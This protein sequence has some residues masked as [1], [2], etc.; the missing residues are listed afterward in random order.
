MATATGAIYSLPTEKEGQ[1]AMSSS[2][3]SSL[4][5]VAMPAIIRGKEI[6]VPIKVDL[7][8]KGARLVDTFC[9]NLYH[10][11]ML[12]EEF[13]AR[14]CTDL[15]LPIGFHSRVTLQ[16]VEQIQA[17]QILVESIRMYAP[18]SIPNWK[19][20]VC[21]IQPITIG[22][23][24]GSIDFSDKVDW[25]PM[26]DC[27][28]PEDFAATTT[29]DLGLP[30][31]IEPA[32]AHKI[33]EALFRW[34]Y[35]IVQNPMLSPA[36]TNLLPEFK[37]NETKVNFVSPNQVVDMVTSLWKRAK[38]SSL[39]EVAAAPQPQLPIDKETNASI[40]NHT[41]SSAALRPSPV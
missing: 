6:L 27:L 2:S 3:S 26:D 37:V 31:E 41:V 1:Q 9:W 29:A 21:Q 24:H 22:I 10:P 19:S 23:R 28:S 36:E 32:I 25:N 18:N 20:K 15:N 14:T 8:Y 35:N 12:P 30:P 5:R 40:W 16:I 13:V 38:P 7:T 39:E 4:T 11:V 33:R 34:L 17:Y